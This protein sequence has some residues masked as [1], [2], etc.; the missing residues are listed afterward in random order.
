MDMDA[1]FV[2]VER[3]DNPFL[4]G[5]PCAVC[6]S[7]SRSVITSA[8][9]EARTY[10][11][12]AGMS[13]KEAKR[14]CPQLIL[15][16]GNHKKYESTASRIF[17][18]LKDYTPLV[19]VA[20]IDEAYLDITDSLI[21]FG[22]PANIA[23]SIKE[24]IKNKEKLT[25]SIGIG[26][27]KLIAKLGSRLGKP[28]GLLI[29][30]KENL[31]SFLEDLPVSKMIGIGPKLTASLN[32]MGVFTCGQLAKIDPLVL[33][34]RFGAIGQR[35]Y[36]IAS[37]L[38]EEPIIPFDVEEP[39]KSISNYVTLKKDSS[40]FNFLR[41]VLLQL[42]EKVAQRMRNEGLFGKRV[43]LSVRYSNFYTLTKQ[44]TLSR[45]TS[46]G[47]EIFK[48]VEEIFY[49]ISHPKPIRLLGVKV[50]FLRKEGY[51]LE[52][53]EDLDKK[54]RLLKALDDVNK[55]YGN[56]TLTWGGLY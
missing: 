53:F 54:E 45:W 15:V 39:Q 47:N 21:L 56:W 8:S 38:D 35:L 23:N 20:S 43:T 19:E 36:E 32:A 24:I 49:S 6:G 18:I 13:I 4:Q 40:N 10:G 29:I 1:F 30:D 51:Q 14:K 42:S 17:S 27:N 41:K 25:C 2:S 55:R 52:L 9:Y 26:P 3:R 50:S 16:K 33:N 34:K 28:D 44:K 48:E 11:I 46:S 12:R 7:L 37:G 22:S 31:K 5:K